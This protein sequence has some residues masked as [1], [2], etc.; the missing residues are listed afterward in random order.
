MHGIVYTK[1]CLNFIIFNTYPS[2]MHHGENLEN[3]FHL[4]LV[5]NDSL[6]P[7]LTLCYKI[8]AHM[9]DIIV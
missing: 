9:N 4:N 2:F 3:N 7:N 8:D 6:C 1:K 5:K